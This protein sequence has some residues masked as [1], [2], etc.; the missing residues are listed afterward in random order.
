MK[1]H[2]VMH[3]SFESPGAILQ[4]AEE[5]GHELSFTRL[6][7]YESLPKSAEDFDF[8]IVMGGPQ[9]PDTADCP[10]YNAGNE[11]KLISQ[12]ISANKIV[13]GVCLGAQLIGE[14]LGARF[15]HSPN[16]EIGVFNITK[17]SEAESDPVFSRFPQTFPMGHWHGDMPGLTPD[18]A[19][20]AYSEG[21]PR[22]VVR[23]TPRVYGFQC[24]F[25][26]THEAIEGMI[27]HCSKDLNTELPYIQSAE[28]LRAH[29]YTAINVYLFDFLDY[30]QAQYDLEMKIRGPGNR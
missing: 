28:E 13:L 5:K 24:H 22:Q 25:E 19:I 9:D 3:E 12:A 7:D 15:E 23:Y 20:L 21:C 6:Y 30:M 17:T 1:I 2:I 27:K 29:D 18:A 4:W 8:L 26:F 11:I 16:R 10:H 14:A